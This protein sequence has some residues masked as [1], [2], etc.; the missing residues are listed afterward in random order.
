MEK[1]GNH[2]FSF[3]LKIPTDGLF[4]NLLR[5]CCKGAIHYRKTGS[6]KLAVGAVEAGHDL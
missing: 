5:L 2:V 6:G 3:V 4:N 1:T